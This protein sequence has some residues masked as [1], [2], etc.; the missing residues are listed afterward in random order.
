[1]NRPD[2]TTDPRRLAVRILD[3]V[4]RTD[5]Y[6]DILLNSA[7]RNNP[8][9]DPDKALA[10]ELVY[11]TLRWWKLLDWI[12][13]RVF[14]GEWNEVPEP[15]RRDC[16]I[17]LARSCFSTGCRLIGVDEAEPMAESGRQVEAGG[18]RGVEKR[19]RKPEMTKVPDDAGNTAER[20][21]CSFA[22]DLAG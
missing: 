9:S 21:D 19:D 14:R 12:L 16:E 6:A 13:C 2:P 7:F 10:T 3:R 8:V 20:F 22:P 5:S 1:M 15:V 11:G 4:F 18:K 17:A